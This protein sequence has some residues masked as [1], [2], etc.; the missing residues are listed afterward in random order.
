[1]LGQRFVRP[2]AP[3]SPIRPQARKGSRSRVGRVY[4]NKDQ[5]FAEVPE[6]AW[7]FHID[8]YRPARG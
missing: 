1:M 8:G 5:Y 3:G 4:I 6:I 2:L 7:G